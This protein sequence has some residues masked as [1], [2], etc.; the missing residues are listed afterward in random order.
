V[1]ATTA[2]GAAGA[3]ARPADGEAAD[4]PTEAMAKRVPAPASTAAA[5]PARPAGGTAAV[6]AVSGETGRGLAETITVTSP[7]ANVVRSTNGTRWWRIRDGNTIEGSFDGGFT[8]TAEY[9]DPQSQIARGAVTRTDDC[10]MVGAKGLVLRFQGGRGWT[11][12][13]P[14][15]TRGLVSV[16]PTSALAATVADESGQRYQTTDGGLTWRPAKR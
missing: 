4:K 6:D 12:V 16:T 9:S 13:T 11:R 8:W 5:A 7:Y 14:P 15:T 3:G 2:A 1:P 10:W